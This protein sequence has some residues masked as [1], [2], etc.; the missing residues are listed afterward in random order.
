MTYRKTTPAI[1]KA[2]HRLRTEGRSIRTIATELQ[3]TK[4][5]IEGALKKAA[6][7]LPVPRR[8]APAPRL[9][10][11]RRIREPAP[12]PDAPPLIRRVYEEL[13]SAGLF[14]ELDCLIISADLDVPR[15]RVTLNALDADSLLARI[16]AAILPGEFIDL[17]TAIARLHAAFAAQDAERQAVREARSAV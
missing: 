2:A 12:C 11:Y 9:E 1:I 7:A 3:T 8:A 13:V 16:E 5:V 14:G 6:P 15:T 4:A 17:D 10:I